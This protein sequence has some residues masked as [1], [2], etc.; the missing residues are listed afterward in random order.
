MKVKSAGFL[1]LC[2]TLLAMSVVFAGLFMAG[3]I[4]RGNDE[5]MSLSLFGSLVA[6]ILG[7]V[8]TKV[9]TDPAKPSE[10]NG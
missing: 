1:A 2:V 4:F 9:A 7:I 5:G 10:R 3:M 6:L 8:M